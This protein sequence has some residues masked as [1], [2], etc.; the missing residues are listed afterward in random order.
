MTFLRHVGEDGWPPEV[1]YRYNK[2]LLK[3]KLDK[4]GV[5]IVEVL[6]LV[7]D[8]VAEIGPVPRKV[9]LEVDNYK[10]DVS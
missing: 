1:W 7:S 5:P 10:G 2:S 6:S 3:L 8:R 9:F 4:D